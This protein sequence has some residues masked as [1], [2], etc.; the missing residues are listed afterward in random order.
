M[1]TRIPQSKHPALNTSSSTSLSCQPDRDP[2]DPSSLAL[3]AV[4]IQD[5]L[6]TAP[7]LLGPIP[8]RSPDEVSLDRG[9]NGKVMRKRIVPERMCPQGR[10]RQRCW[11]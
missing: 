8:F 7:E 5:H 6:I 4:Q 1:K 10:Q 9:F 2:G 3:Y 11:Y